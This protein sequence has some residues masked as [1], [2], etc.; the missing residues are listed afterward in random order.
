MHKWGGLLIRD[1][2]LFES[3][4]NRWVTLPSKPYEVDGKKKYFSYLAFEERNLDDKF[5]EMILKE[6]NSYLEKHCVPKK[7]EIQKEEIG[8]LPF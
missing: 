6:A 4:A 1:C 3:G 7:E 8:D 2:T 5:K